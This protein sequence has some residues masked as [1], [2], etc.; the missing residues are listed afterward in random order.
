MVLGL[1]GLLGTLTS[2]ALAQNPVPLIN[3]PLVPDAAKPGGTGFTLTVNGTGFVSGSVVNWNGSARV[4]MFVNSAQ[5]KAS[6]PASDIATAGTASVTVVNPAL[7]GGKS[8][9]AFF[10]I[11]NPSPFIS[12]GRSDFG[13]G[14]EAESVTTGDFNGDG[15]LD[16]AVA[17]GEGDNT[18]SV[19]LGNGD[20]TFQPQV[21]YPTGVY[22]VWVIAA[23]FNRDGKLD[24]AVSNAF[25][26]SVSILLGNGDGT[27][28]GRVDYPTG[29]TV[30]NR[31]MVAADFNGDGYLDLALDL[32]GDFSGT[33]VVIFLGNGDGTFREPATYPTGLGP[34]SVTAGDFN[35]DGKLD[36][37]MA[38]YNDGAGNSVSVLLGNGDGTFQPPVE[39]ATGTG[40][41]SVATGDFNGDGILDLAT[42][43]GTDNKISVLLGNGDGTFQSD[44]DYGVGNSPLFVVAGDFNGDNKLD[45]VVTNTSTDNTVSVLLGNGNGT[46]QPQL[47]FSTNARA[48]GET[49]GDFNGDGRLDLAVADT[50]SSTVSVLLQV[51]TV[52]LSKARLTFA[53]QLIG[54]TSPAHMFAVKNT[55][56]VP[57]NFSSIAITG[58]NAT[59]FAAT[60]TCKSSVPPGGH[61]T[62]CV[63]F[64]PTAEGTRSGTV[65]ITD[66]AANSP[67]TVALTGTGTVVELSP[68][69]VDFGNQSVGTRSPA[70]KLTL[71]NTGTTALSITGIGISGPDF[72][73]FAYTTTCDSS[74]AAKADCLIYVT[75]KPEATGSRTA[76]V[77]VFDSGGG[78]PQRVELTGTGT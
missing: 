19:L 68:A 71:T 35:R 57:L 13:V 75:F 34:H 65:T 20:G 74:L 76:S 61:C 52:S 25:S 30:D 70:R 15:K 43:D 27:F 3:Q 44:V 2:T 48:F 39:Y 32:T 17:N 54:T 50:R 6:I 24:L 72:D 64:K 4:T 46:F 73:D 37:A 29:S 38:N 40:P 45:L 42:A 62:V 33:G 31:S 78:S 7:G 36:L 28:Q 53:D 12:L 55:G 1:F 14:T 77:D 22:P 56:G 41:Y 18:V 10:S 59:D 69:T 47:V 5:L 11:T 60:D 63:T 58:T 66:N 9:V 16:L 26:H 8:N 23:D 67:Q 21:T 49:I 51:A